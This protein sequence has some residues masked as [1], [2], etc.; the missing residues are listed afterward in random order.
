MVFTQY[1]NINQR[2]VAW[3]YYKT[4]V[5]RYCHTVLVF[6]SNPLSIVPINFWAKMSRSR[7][8]TEN[9]SIM[10]YNEMRMSK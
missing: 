10:V 8:S 9:D 1:H 5:P 4:T 2:T 7:C 6:E 3:H